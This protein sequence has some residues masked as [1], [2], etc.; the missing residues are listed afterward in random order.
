MKLL[1]V[2]ALIVALTQGLRFAPAHQ[3]NDYTEE[4]L[5]ALIKMS[6]TAEEWDDMLEFTKE[7]VDLTDGHLNYEEMTLFEPPLDM[8]IVPGKTAWTAVRDL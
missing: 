1:V 7:L 4:Q 5:V 6:Q 8:H 2:L 3:Q